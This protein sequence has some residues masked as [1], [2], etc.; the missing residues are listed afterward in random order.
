MNSDSRERSRAR[1]GLAL[2]SVTAVT[3]AMLT[4]AP[5]F[6]VIESPP[7]AAY[8]VTIFPQR[9]F[10]SVVWNGA[11]KALTFD[12]SRS[13]VPI[14]NAASDQVAPLPD[15]LTA[16][17]EEAVLEVNH[18]G[19]LCWNGSTPDILPG[20]QLTVVESGTTNGVS[21]TTLNI[22][23]E[24]AVIEG[25][26]VVV[27][28]TALNSEGTAAMDLDLVEQRIINPDLFEA[29]DS[30]SLRA[31]VG[32]DDGT[33]AGR[34]D[35]LG[36]WI[37]TYTGLSPRDQELAVTGQTRGMA[38]MATDALGNRL[39]MTIFEADETGGP[40]MGECPAAAENSVAAA[41]PA[42]VNAANIAGGLTLSGASFDASSVT[43]S[44]DDANPATTPVTASGPTGSATGASSYSA[45][46]TGAQ[47]ATLSDGTLT[48]TS[49]FTRAA[50]TIAGSGMTV[51][52]DTVV[53][54]APTTDTAPGTYPSAQSIRL[55]RAAGEAVSSVVH[56]TTDGSAP[57]AA[58]PTS[59]P[60]AITSSRTVR[61]VVVDTA[62]NVSTPSAF[63]YTISAPL[64]PVVVPPAPAGTAGTAGTAG[65]GGTAGTAG[66]AAIV[67]LA[68]RIGLASSGALGGARTALAR[69]AAPRANGAVVDGYQVRAL[70]LRPGRA[71]KALPAVVAGRSSRRLKLSLPA[72]TYRFQVRATSA[73]GNSPWSTASNKVVAR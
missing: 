31:V 51:L 49:S 34:D 57:T 62:G 45:T 54:L 30:R 50:D 55:S 64:A 52:K 53:P 48:A 36:G 11:G 33:L 38:W 8:E 60:I 69:W 32:G 44:L 6:A 23:A 3:T 22:T 21:A 9:D 56:Y 10:V 59:Q 42:A 72:G 46:F 40:G 67:P 63:A 14:G 12:L 37:A 13:G 19:G 26:N 2:V 20:D 5:A 1:W 39:G 66:T 71:A 28:G 15:I 25:G 41:A 68:P 61:A 17:G 73:A 43:I 70:R 7:S 35:V 27:R 47:L 4:P 58:S 18:P 65:A 29:S 24:P 16:Q